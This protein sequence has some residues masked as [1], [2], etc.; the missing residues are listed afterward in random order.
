MRSSSHPALEG[1]FGLAAPGQGLQCS[2]LQSQSGEIDGLRV[3]CLGRVLFRDPD[4]RAQAGTDGLIAALAAG[5]RRHGPQ[6]LSRITGE[7]ALA[8]ADTRLNTGLVAVDRYSTLAMYIG[9]HD[10]QWAFASEPLRVAALLGRKPR[11]DAAALH[12]YVFFHVIPAP[13]SIIEGVR[14]LDIGEYAVFEH[15]S[16]SVQRYWSPV[17]EEANPFDFGQEKAA[18]MGALRQSVAEASEGTTRANLGCFLSGGTD[19]STISG[20]A[21]EMLGGGV[22]TFSIGFDVQAYDESYYYRLAAKHFKTEHTEFVLNPS[23]AGELLDVVAGQFEQPFGNA[24]ALPTLFC[25]QLA[26][27]AGITRMLGG[28]GGDELYG[29]NERY[30]TQAL[31]A[32]Y[33]QVPAIVRNGLLEP[34]LF[35]PLKSSEFALF[36]KARGYIEQAKT[37]LPDRL[38]GKYNLL[39]RFGVDRVFEPAVIA[40]GRGFQ[41]LALE[42][43]VWARSDAGTQINRLL[44]FDFKFTLGDGDLPKVTRMCHAAGVEVAFPMLSDLMTD[45]SLRLAPSQKLKRTKLRYFFK[46][47]LRGFLPDEIL[48]KSKH[49]FGM[50]FG[51]WM[52]AQ[53]ELAARA[54]DALAGLATRG[55]VRAEF[56]EQ[57]RDAVKGG[58]A[59]YF[60]VMIWVLMMLELWLRAHM[61]DASFGERAP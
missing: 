47:A 58:H 18:F 54:D 37:P 31:F 43:D 44:A 35:G 39:N 59:G 42:R 36:R 16:M 61:P 46:E 41:P 40:S 50:P 30:A 10:G 3:A 49:G 4:L 7:F 11:L 53:P 51:D 48:T 21:S 6:V 57:L 28:D 15:G 33:D 17:F 22:R 1:G 13:L 55:I 5:Y 19:S 45:H 23:H 8:F 27:E 26:R 24:S 14:R 52:L 38:G 25:A 34:L 9:S 29:G 12:A 20:M 32:F 56:I 60:G 2:G